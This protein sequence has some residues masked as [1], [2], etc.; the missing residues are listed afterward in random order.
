MKDVPRIYEAVSALFSSLDL[1]AAGLHITAS[2]LDCGLFKVSRD[3][4][5]RP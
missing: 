5:T 2:P 4:A 1:G 3:C